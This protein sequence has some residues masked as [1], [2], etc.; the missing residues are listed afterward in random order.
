LVD[1]RCLRRGGCPHMLIPPW[2]RSHWEPARTLVSPLPVS[3][4]AREGSE[5]NTVDITN[6]L[7]LRCWIMWAPFD[8][9]R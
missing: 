8:G 1:G 7:R 9:Q 6:G 4:F 2:K 3:R 5:G